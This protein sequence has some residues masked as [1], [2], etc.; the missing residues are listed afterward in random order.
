MLWHNPVTASF[1]I[2]IGT[3]VSS[4]IIGELVCN[5]FPA[6]VSRMGLDGENP[7]DIITVGGTVFVL[8]VLSGV[9]LWSVLELFKLIKK[10]WKESGG[11]YYSE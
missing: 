1:I 8:I 4:W 10:L 6:N 9:S 7:G 2:A 11:V 5:N 3:F